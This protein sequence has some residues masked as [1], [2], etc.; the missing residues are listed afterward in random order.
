MSHSTR[1]SLEVVLLTIYPEIFLLPEMPD[2]VDSSCIDPIA[3][4]VISPVTDFPFSS[5]LAKNGGSHR[6]GAWAHRSN[7][8]GPL[9]SIMI[10][11]TRNGG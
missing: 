2:K 5:K 3:N 10:T 8:A 11:D 4:P 7:T 1:V 6:D 9:L